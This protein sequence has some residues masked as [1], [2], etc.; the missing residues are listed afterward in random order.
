MVWRLLGASSRQQEAAALGPYWAA[1]LSGCGVAV[2]EVSVG[3]PWMVAKDW[4]TL[5]WSSG[6][7]RGPKTWL[8]TAV[9]P[10]DT[11]K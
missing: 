7:M 11:C 3:V 1:L 10:C 2:T 8:E 6:K 5:T 9:L 4:F